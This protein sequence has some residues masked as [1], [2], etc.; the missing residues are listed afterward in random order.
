MQ[1]HPM[2]RLLQGDV[3]SGKTI[4]AALAACRAI[5]AGWQAAFMAPTGDSAEQHHQAD[6][7]AGTAG[8]RV[9]WL[10][11]EPEKAGKGDAGGSASGAQ[12]IVGTHALIQEAV[13]FP[14]SGWRSSMNSTDSA[15]SSGWRCARRASGRCWRRR[16]RCSAPADDVGDADPAHAGDEL[17]RRPRRVGARRIAAGADA[18]VPGWSPTGDA[19]R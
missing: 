8:V 6:V 5:E 15:C 16:G 11:G 10:S 14:A 19:T 4:V 7:L 2:Q 13:D 18:D 12:L 3:G 9:A 17:L 1:P